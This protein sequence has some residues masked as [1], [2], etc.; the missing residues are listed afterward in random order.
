MLLMPLDAGPAMGS[1]QSI[2]AV[3]VAT[4]LEESARVGGA[5]RK[6]SGVNEAFATAADLDLKV[7]RYEA[8]EHLT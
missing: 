4:G 5:R 3:D 8:A 1:G 2:Q 6:E 7:G